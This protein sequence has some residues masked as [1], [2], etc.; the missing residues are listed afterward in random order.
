MMK[1]LRILS[2]ILLASLGAAL[3]GCIEDGVS[4]SPSDQPVFSTDTLDMGVIFTAEAA[5]THRMLVHNPHKKGMNISNIRISGAMADCFRIN[6]DGMSGREFSNVEI[7]EKD[8]IFVLVG[9]TLPENGEDVPVKVTASL[10]FTVNGV[11]N[12]VILAA[13][14]QNV[15]RLSGTVLD[16]DTRFDA[17]RPYKIFDSLVVAEGATLTLEAGTTLCFHDKSMLIVRGTL[18]S[19]GTVEAPVTMAGD[20]TGN[21]VSDISFDIMSRQWTG[22]FFTATSH[23][24]YLA[25]TNIRNTWQGVAISGD[26][27]AETPALT[28]VNCRLRNSGGLVFESVHSNVLAAGCEFAEGADG[29]VY[30]QGGTAAFNHCTFANYYLFSALGGPAVEFAHI[31]VTAEPEL[32][33]DDGS[34]LP[35]LAADFSNSIVY[36]LGNDLSHG[37]L[38][39]SKVFFR[40]CLLK[41]EGSDDD[42][43]L[44]CIWNEDPLYY[45]VREDYIFDYRLRP[46]SPAAGAGDAALTLPLAATDGYGMTRGTAPDLGAY[47]FT[48]EAVE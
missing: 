7:R 33:F 40:R 38:T 3:T 41:S 21:V 12:S 45:T 30:L 44:N 6:V 17:R 22:V 24:N 8:S 48:P 16:T 27:T 47:V 37:D 36:G 32:Q 20:R 10:D 15:R 5:P 34:G 35:F 19:E 25:N 9:A 42:N 14:G 4:S 46:D 43:F 26:G 13:S 1:S 28:M 39:G 23:A 2:L 18:V 31:G 29:L 11:T